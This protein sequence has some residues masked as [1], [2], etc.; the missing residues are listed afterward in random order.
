MSRY[1]FAASAVVLAVLA[2]AGCRSPYYADKG[3]LFGGLAG[4]GVGAAIGDASGGNALPGAIIGSAV[5]AITGSVVGE[6]IDAD[7]ARNRAEVEARMGRQM[8]GAV[9][10]EGVIAMTR[11]GL[12]ESVIA[13]HIRANGV[14]RPLQVNDLI[15][16][17]NQGV[18]D[19]VIVTLQ[20]TPPPMAAGTAVVAQPVPGPVIVEHYYAPPPPPPFFF[21]Y[22]RGWCPPR[23]CPP[24][25]GVSW[26]VSVAN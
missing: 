15:H 8:Q 19:S 2:S 21:H 9:T 20:Q 26:G 10:P 12:S 17:R 18:P 22:G 5:G 25:R 1:S 23:H 4:A 11:A 13:T 6:G 7:I 24:R 3:A 14:A 16:L